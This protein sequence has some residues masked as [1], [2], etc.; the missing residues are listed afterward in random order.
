[1]VHILAGWE[2]LFVRRIPS[3]L[4]NLGKNLSHLLKTFH[5]DV[6]TRSQLSGAGTAT[7]PMLEQQLVN[8]EH[9]F[10]ASS[11]EARTRIDSA[12]RDINRE[13]VPSITNSMIPGYIKCVDERGMRENTIQYHLV[14]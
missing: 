5:S 13:F 7:I 9:V 11:R 12:Q 1:M 10:D 14:C 4:S 8:Y 3:V 2:R 6:A